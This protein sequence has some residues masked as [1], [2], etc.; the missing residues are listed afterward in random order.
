MDVQ[1]FVN[2]CVHCWATTDGIRVPRPFGPVVHGSTPN[3]VLQF[4]YMEFSLGSTGEKYVLLFRDDHSGYCLLFPFA[5][6]NA[7]NAAHA[8][9]D[10]CAAPGVPSELISD[11]PAH[12]R[13]ENVHLVTKALQPPSSLR[14]HI[15]PSAMVLLRVLDE[16]YSAMHAPS[17]PY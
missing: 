1:A 7:K 11:G 2:S 14:F 8:I 5:D 16:K 13:N 4:D 10:W 3:D 6:T 15:A 12:F 9:I 17:F